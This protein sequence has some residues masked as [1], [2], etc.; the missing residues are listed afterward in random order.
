MRRI[1]ILLLAASASVSLG[2]AVAVSPVGNGAF[3]TDVKGPVQAT[4][5]G[6]AS[7]SG[8]ACARNILGLVAT[9]D[10]SIETA[11]ANGSIQTVTTVDHTSYTVFGL[12]SRFCTV[13]RGE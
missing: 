1:V 9:G 3:F 5:E 2:C 4:D 7:R 6:E 13:V 12:Y 8:E 10:A 11:K